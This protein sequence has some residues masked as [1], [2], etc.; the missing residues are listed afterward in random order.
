MRMGKQIRDSEKQVIKTRKVITMEI[1]Y[2]Y[3]TAAFVAGDILFYTNRDSENIYL[4]TFM[5]PE[6]GWEEKN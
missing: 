2:D 4:S 3:Q 6:E 5:I 1:P